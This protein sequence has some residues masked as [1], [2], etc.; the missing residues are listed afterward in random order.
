MRVHDPRVGGVSYGWGFRRYLL[1]GVRPELV[2]DADR[3]ISKPAAGGLELSGG[4]D[5]LADDVEYIGL[6]A[7]FVTPDIGA[8][9]IRAFPSSADVSVDY[10]LEPGGARSAAPTDEFVPG[11][12]D[13]WSVPN[14]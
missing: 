8:T 7:P 9:L 3:Q 12:N 4:F 5:L 11:D 13:L 1:D 2:I 10:L 14:G 6:A